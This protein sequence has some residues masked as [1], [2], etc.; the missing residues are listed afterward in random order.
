MNEKIRICTFS[1][2]GTTFLC[3]AQLHQAAISANICI[4][5]LLCL[6]KINFIGESAC[7]MN[8]YWFLMKYKLEAICF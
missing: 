5:F 8:K 7:L 6:E 3:K 2:S 1:M 4:T